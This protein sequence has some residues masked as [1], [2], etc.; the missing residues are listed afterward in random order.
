MA[1]T[2]KVK[3]PFRFPLPE[4]KMFHILYAFKKI[5]SLLLNWFNDLTL[6]GK[7]SVCNSQILM[8]LRRRHDFCDFM[9]I[10]EAVK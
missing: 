1:E 7:T 2:V 10:K 4:I 3:T 9:K 6:K 5:C 8:A